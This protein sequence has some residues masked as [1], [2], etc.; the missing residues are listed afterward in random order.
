MALV[1]D[2]KSRDALWIQI[3]I[4]GA[5]KLLA[6]EL[7]LCT[8]SSA[9]ST[10]NHWRRGVK[11]ISSGMCCRILGL[12]ALNSLLQYVNWLVWEVCSVN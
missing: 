4:A 7:F 8:K 3:Y 11:E 9:L 5:F 2:T 1:P 6:Y 10:D 12:T